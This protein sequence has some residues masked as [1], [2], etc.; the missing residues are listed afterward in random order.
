LWG[1]FLQKFINKYSRFTNIG[2]AGI[3]IN[4]SFT[5]KEIKN[6]HT[7]HYERGIGFSFMP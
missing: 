4:L 3:F 5:A 1:F 6:P 2:E 7:L